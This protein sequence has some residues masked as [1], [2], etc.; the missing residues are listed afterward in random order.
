MRIAAGFTTLPFI[1]CYSVFSGSRT[2]QV[3]EPAAEISDIVKSGIGGDGRN[4]HFRILEEPAGTLKSVF[5][6]II[7]RRCV[8]HSEGPG[9]RR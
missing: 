3:L 8:Y 6:Q 7:D 2:K 9:L 1:L 5:Y 4:A